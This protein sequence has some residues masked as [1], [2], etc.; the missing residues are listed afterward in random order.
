MD[1]QKALVVSAV[2]AKG[3]SEALHELRCAFS[4]ELDRAVA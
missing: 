4:E 1:E 3:V 2:E